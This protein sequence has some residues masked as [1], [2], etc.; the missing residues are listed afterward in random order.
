MLGIL[1]KISVISIQKV[2]YFVDER[3]FAIHMEDVKY[4]LFFM[5]KSI[6]HSQ[7]GNYSAKD[8]YHFL[9]LVQTALCPHNNICARSLHHRKE[10]CG[11]TGIK[12][13]IVPPGQNLRRLSWRS[14]LGRRWQ[15]YIMLL[16]PIVYVV[17]FSY[18][19]MGGIII[20][21][22]QYSV[23]R[24]IWG[25]NWVGLKY[26]VDFV[27][28]PNFSLLLKNTLIISILSIAVGFPMPVLLALFVNECASVRY[29]KLVQTVTYAPYF[30]SMVV[31]CG[32][33]LNFLSLRTG[34]VNNIIKLF[35]GTQIN[36]M[37]EARMFR[38]IYVLTDV[39]KNM[40][41]GA[42]LYI[43]SLASVDRNIVEASIIDGA[44]RLR[45]VWHVDLPTI[46]PTIIIQLIMAVGGI[47]SLG[48][49]KIFLLQNPVNVEVSE[50]IS[51]FVYKRGLTQMQYSYATAVGLF[52][53]VVNLIL[54]CGAN[55]IARRVNGTS[56]W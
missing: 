19:P 8:A 23:K 30:I 15:L 47:M 33:I 10:R 26:F 56:L 5:R 36:F 44:S 45:R 50:I 17:I 4:A 38:A 40:G 27:N 32:L 12:S 55:W 22:K 9:F 7:E 24:G 37:G 35:G 20:A 1:Q 34:M 3:I 48:F 14:E 11:L 25:S 29:R 28:T 18:I 41:Y 52:N 16:L 46:A 42:V 49:E 43:A 31:M 6:T 54:I 39:W 13:R 2:S 21:F 51:T 53:S